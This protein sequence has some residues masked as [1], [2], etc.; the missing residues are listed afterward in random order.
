MPT[1]DKFEQLIEK[2]DLDYCTGLVL[3]LFLAMA[4][5][6][7]TIHFEISDQFMELLP[8]HRDYVNFLINDGV[9][10]HYA[11]S[12]ETRRA[13]ITMNA[14]TKKEVIKLLVKSPLY[15]FWT[16][17]VDE[18]YVLDGQHYRLPSMQWN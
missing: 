12:M 2:I 11:V 7:V 6:Q 4:K 13:W 14:E 1:A 10:D 15:R 18:I 17:E 9:I 16:N 5:Y 3:I 8:K